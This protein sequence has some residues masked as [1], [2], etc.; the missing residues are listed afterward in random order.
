MSLQDIRSKIDEVDDE[1][2]DLFLQRMKLVAEVAEFKKDSD[3]PVINVKREREILDRVS[4]KAGPRLGRYARFVYNALFDVARSWQNTM[5]PAKSKLRQVIEEA[6]KNTPVLFPETASVAC[7]G[8]EGAY[9]QDAAEKVFNY[10]RIS[11]F[12]SFDSVFTAVEKG[13]CKYGILPIE[14]SSYGSVGRVYDL[15]REHNFHISRSTRLRVA[16]KLMVKPGTSLA[17]VREITSHE[18]ALG[19]CQ[20]FLRTLPGVKITSCEN[21]AQAARMV[22]ESGR[23]D[24]A[25]ISSADCARLYGLEIIKDDIQISDNNYTRFI[26]IYKDMEIYPGSN[27]LSIMMSLPHRPMSLYHTIARFST[28]GVN[29]TKLESRPIP[30][31]DFEFMFYFDMEASLANEDI[32]N[33]ICELDQSPDTFVCLGNY[34]E[35]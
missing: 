29:L 27:K 11:F 7:Q 20:A 30:G 23:S 22:A 21:T 14:N 6:M 9:S 35:V 2:L 19:Q 17:D 5:I 18:Q 1:L 13:L 33:L 32:R 26:C 4:E 3:M 10:P 34:T 28:L 16:H 8:V 24:M 25:A 15:M 12:N 31:S